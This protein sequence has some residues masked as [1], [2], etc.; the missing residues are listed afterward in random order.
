MITMLFWFHYHWTVQK[1]VCGNATLMVVE[2]RFWI[3]VDRMK[4]GP[5]SGLK[6]S[7]RAVPKQ[8]IFTARSRLPAATRDRPPSG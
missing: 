4:L 2:V 6:K 8:G 5:M 7:P 1:G 3:D